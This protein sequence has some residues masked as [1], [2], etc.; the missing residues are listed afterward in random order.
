MTP[1]VKELP[2]AA[3]SLDKCRTYA[4]L[5]ASDIER[6]VHFYAERL[7]LTPA[8]QVPGHYFYECAGTQFLLFLSQG[9]ASG[10]HDQMGWYV[11]DIESEVGTL[12]FRGVRFETFDLPG[13][14]WDGE[15]ADNGF[16][17]SAWFRDSEGNLLN[18]IQLLD[19]KGLGANRSGP[20][21]DETPLASDRLGV[22]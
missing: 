4:K 19:R 6:A 11:A 13:N 15:I 5:P 7:G 21:S 2:G 8:T 20:R 9:R 18:I 12:K 22:G 17:R 10:N 3:P 14:R 1:P 16:R